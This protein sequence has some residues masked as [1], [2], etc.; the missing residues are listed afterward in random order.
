MKAIFSL[1]AYIHEHFHMRDKVWNFSALR[2]PAPTYSDSAWSAKRCCT[3]TH[4]FQKRS[5][6]CCVSA[7][8]KMRLPSGTEDTGSTFN[9]FS[10][11]VSARVR[12]RANAV[13]L[14]RTLV[15]FL[16]LNHKAERTDRTSALAEDASLS[17]F[18][19]RPLLNALRVA[20]EPH[21]ERLVHQR[22]GIQSGGYLLRPV[23]DHLSKARTPSG[24]RVRMR[25]V[26][27]RD[28]RVYQ[29]VFVCFYRQDRI[30]NHT[31]YAMNQDSGTLS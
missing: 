15:E 18:Q 14:Y 23:R 8:F 7:S 20:R 13:S 19:L 24:S 3:V 28:R 1:I 10:A 29:Y 30:L 17:V 9:R 25:L 2:L 11:C 16:L 26:L 12:S 4:S 31:L 27:R 6:I 21:S 22:A 5:P